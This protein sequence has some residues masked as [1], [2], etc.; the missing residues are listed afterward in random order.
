MM[1]KSSE[2]QKMYDEHA[3]MKEAL[4]EIAN[5]RKD[6]NPYDEWEESLAFDRCVEIAEDALK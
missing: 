1:E 5:Y 6:N 4:T 3:K 2:L